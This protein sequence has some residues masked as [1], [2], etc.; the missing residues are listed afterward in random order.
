MP[1]MILLVKPSK[2]SSFDEDGWPS[3]LPLGLT[4]ATSGS[5]PASIS[6]S[7]SVSSPLLAIRVSGF[8]MM[9]DSYSNGSQMLQYSS[10]GSRKPGSSAFRSYCSPKYL[11][12]SPA[13]FNRSATLTWLVGG[14]VN[15]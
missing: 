7:N 13:E 15:E 8:A 4:I 12:E 9:L 3:L 14:M 6:A 5:T 1:S 11:T 2:R 10:L